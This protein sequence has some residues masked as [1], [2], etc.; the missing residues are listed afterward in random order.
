MQL[1][2][3]SRHLMRVMG[4]R[5]RSFKAIKKIILLQGIVLHKHI[6]FHMVFYPFQ[7]KLQIFHPILSPAVLEKKIEVMIL[8]LSVGVGI[9]MTN[10]DHGFISDI[11]EGIYEKLGTYVHYQKC[12]LYHEGDNS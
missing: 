6:L 5:S 11:T 10:F 3:S 2:L 7:N 12:K 1:T 8:V 9:G 4:P